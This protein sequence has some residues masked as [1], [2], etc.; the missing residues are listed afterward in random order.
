VGSELNSAKLGNSGQ[1]LPIKANP[2]RFIDI[3]GTIH[4]VADT[5]EDAIWSFSRQMKLRVF[6][7]KFCGGYCQMSEPT[8]VLGHPSS[9]EVGWPESRN[10]SG[11]PARIRRR[12][13]RADVVDAGFASY[14][15]VPKGVLADA[16]GGHDAEAGNYYATGPSQ[17]SL[18]DGSTT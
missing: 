11:Y 10:L 7:C 13:E 15:S 17:R 1:S 14:E 9:H 5:S 3:S 4:G 6:E 2:S 18:P 12:I 8:G 16:V